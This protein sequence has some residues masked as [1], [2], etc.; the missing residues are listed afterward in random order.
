MTT[1]TDQQRHRRKDNKMNPTLKA[2][3][4]QD[5]FSFAYKAIVELEGT[6]LGDQPYLRY[7]A[8]EL[9]QFARNETR[10]LIINLPPGHLKTLL[11]SVCLSA[12]LLAH[13]PSRKI[14]IV[15]H[16]EH[17]SKTI[18]RNIRAILQSRWFEEVFDTRVKKGHAEVTDFGTTGGGGVFV[19]SFGSRYTGHRADVI[20]V[21]DPHDIGDGVEQIEGTIE[22]FYKEVLSR[23]NDRKAGRVMVVA[24]RVYERDLSAHLLRKKNWKHVA[25]PLVATQDQSYKTLWGD[26]FRRE[27]HLLRP[28]AFGPDDI[29]ELRE[30][31]FS[32]DF[33]MLYQQNVDSQA[34]PAIRPDHFQTFSGSPPLGP[35][36]LSVDAGVANRRTSA[37]SVIQAWCLAG[38]RYYLIDQFREQTDFADLRDQLRRFR[39]KYRPAA[40]LIER[41]ANGHALISELSRS[42][43]SALLI[44]VE[45]DGRSKSARLRIHAK[46][47]IAKR[48]FLPIH[49]PWRGTFVDELVAYPHGDF[50][51][52]IDAMTQ[53]LDHAP[54]LAGLKPTLPRGLG[55]MTNGRTMISLSRGRGGGLPEVV[56]RIG[57][58]VGSSQRITPFPK[59]KR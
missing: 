22:S 54:E 6:R 31:C 26:W 51:D 44:P 12:W 24:H 45:L 18:A 46:T 58:P 42:R 23:L 35:V 36:V 11:G 47:I 39:N 17:L 14:I 16:A 3:L 40:I 38:D 49:A 33:E 41:S 30:T 37:F 59:V 43:H 57:R 50:T 5:F 7:L 20:I 27:G 48:I 8:T 52:Q 25:L 21:D 2:A 19:T 53:V 28:D 13:D 32:P 9:D 4:Q 55:S 29:E 34:L 10:R 1:D 56:R 15:T